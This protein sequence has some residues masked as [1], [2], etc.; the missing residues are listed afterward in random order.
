MDG[1]GV[2]ATEVTRVKNSRTFYEVLQV[3]TD[4]SEVRLPDACSTSPLLTV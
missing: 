2:D 4:A 1:V 3:A